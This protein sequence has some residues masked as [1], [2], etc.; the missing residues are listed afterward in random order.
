MGSLFCCCKY[1]CL[2]SRRAAEVCRRAGPALVPLW[3]PRGPPVM[4]P[5]SPVLRRRAVPAMCAMCATGAGP[6][7]PAWGCGCVAM[8]TDGRAEGC[9]PCAPCLSPCPP[10]SAVPV[11]LCL[12]LDKGWWGSFL[13][14]LLGCAQS[15]SCCQ[16]DSPQCPREGTP[17][18]RHG[19]LCKGTVP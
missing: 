7:L 5:W 17:G 19:H 14:S 10:C 4:P 13:G 16:A 8:E 2:E 9:P 11:G 15:P 1:T 18:A 6:C 12:L 3:S